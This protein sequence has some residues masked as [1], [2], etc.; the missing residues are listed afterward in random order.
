M[1][2]PAF[3]IRGLSEYLNQ[4]SVEHGWQEKGKR[5][6]D[7]LVALLHTEISEAYEEYRSGHKLTEVYYREDGKPE[8][9]PIELADLAIRLF[10]S[11]QELGIDLTTAITVKALYN[12]RRPYRHGGK[13][14]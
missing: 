10:Q 4:V 11:C 8:G 9:V 2:V 5:P 7:M 12:E 14:A 1:S 13:L 3:D 6:F